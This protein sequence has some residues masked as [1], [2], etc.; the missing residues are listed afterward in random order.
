M[1][2]WA[3]V[4]GI[5]QYWTPAACLSGAVR[6]ADRTTLRSRRIIGNL[7]GEG[8]RGDTR[9]FVADD[10]GELRGGEKT[11]DSLLSCPETVG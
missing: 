11:V 5:D 6:D 10:A 9:L 4:I 7:D 2:N 8:T 1:A 3:I